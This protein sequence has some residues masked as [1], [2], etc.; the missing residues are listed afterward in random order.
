[1]VLRVAIGAMMQE[2]NDFSSVSRLA[3]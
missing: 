2:T 3:M 1:M